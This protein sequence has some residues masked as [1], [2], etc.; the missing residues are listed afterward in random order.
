M[1]SRESGQPF[2]WLPFRQLQ[3]AE[4]IRHRL[5]AV[6]ELVVRASGLD[7]GEVLV[8]IGEIVSEA[9]G[10]SQVGDGG[11]IFALLQKCRA[12]VVESRLAKLKPAYKPKS[13]NKG[14]SV[15]RLSTNIISLPSRECREF[16][17]PT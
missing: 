12:P 16:A 10:L 2:H 14:N 7:P 11:G 1:R 17:W 13:V 8:L 4:G 6:E 5:E 15:Y 3:P 9:H